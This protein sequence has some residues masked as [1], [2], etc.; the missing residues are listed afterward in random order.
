MK[1]IHYE[2]TVISPA[3]CACIY[4]DDTAWRLL[5]LADSLLPV[6][7]GDITV[8]IREVKEGEEA[9]TDGN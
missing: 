1:G 3:K 2:M 7:G 6:A 4:E 5:N 8:R 9:N